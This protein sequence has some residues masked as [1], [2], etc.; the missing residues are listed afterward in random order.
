MDKEHDSKFDAIIFK[1]SIH[2]T[3][4]FPKLFADC[5]KNLKP[6]GRIYIISLKPGSVRPPWTPPLQKKLDDTV[7]HYP[8]YIPSQLFNYEVVNEER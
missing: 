2:F 4:N 8:D 7:L 6:D 5:Y 3:N 1:Y